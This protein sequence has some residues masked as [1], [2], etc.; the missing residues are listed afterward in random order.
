[1]KKMTEEWLI[2]ASDD[3]EACD[4]LISSPGLTNLVAFHAQQC[5]EKSFKA[6]AE[7]AEIQVSKT[8]DLIK[9]HHQLKKYLGNIDLDLLYIVNELYIDARYPGEM[10]LLPDGKPT[11][12][13]AE[14]FVLFGK[15]IFDTI[16]TYLK[17]EIK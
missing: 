3:L 13:E 5:V 10:G 1:M 4:T 17:L 12:K 8:H 11:M 16:S 15:S 6:L 14:S 2:A 9:L 7:E